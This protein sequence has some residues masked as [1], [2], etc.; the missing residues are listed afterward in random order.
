M[1][2][3]WSFRCGLDANV[4]QVS[5]RGRGGEDARVDFWESLLSPHQSGPSLGSLFRRLVVVPSLTNILA[6]LG[7]Q[8]TY[9]S[10][11]LPHLFL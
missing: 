8:T 4:A 10:R 7:K 5:E 3:S 2:K 1:C 6:E 9:P 11:S